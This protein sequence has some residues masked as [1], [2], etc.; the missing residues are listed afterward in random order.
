MVTHP[1]PGSARHDTHRDGRVEPRRVGPQSVIEPSL[2]G[3]APERVGS[4]IGSSMGADPL[5][6]PVEDLE[7]R[8][9]D[10]VAEEIQAVCFQH[11]LDHLD[12][13]LF[14]DRISRLKRNLYVK[15]RKKQVRLEL[16]EA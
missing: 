4:P 15:K 11:E 14:I 12:G 7:G 6:C 5:Q 10:I 2:P 3:H 8:A 16:E 13:V 1:E 9:V